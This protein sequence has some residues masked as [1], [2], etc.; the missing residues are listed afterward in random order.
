MNKAI[1]GLLAAA[2]LLFAAPAPSSAQSYPG[3]QIRLIVPVPAG[4]VT[5][6]MARIVAQRLGEA[7]N[8][9]VIVDNR[10]GGNYSVGVQAVAR[11]PADGLTLLV[12]PD[13]PITANPHLFGKLAYDPIKELTPIIVLCRITPIVVVNEAVPARSI[14]ELIALA[15]KEPG[16]LNYG[17]YG[18]GSYSH[19]SMEDFKKRTGADIVHIPYRGAAPA[20]S[21]LLANTIQMLILNL[22]SIEAHE[23]AGKVRILAAAGAKRAAARP[24]LPT[25]AEAGVPGFSTTAWFALFGP[26]NMAPDLV[27]KIHADVAKALDA[28]QTREFFV[29]NSFERVD[30]NPAQFKELIAQDSRHW[31]A[32]IKQVGAKLD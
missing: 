28:P 3:G 15:K 1:Q 19:L 5:D 32:L 24:D 9:N 29:K 18:I 26:A 13:S 2:L 6:T 11:A 8:Q 30:A 7:L 16:K 10:P 4:G 23:K 31:S 25:V 21:A 14:K 27:T 12:A 17:S 22:S 20:S